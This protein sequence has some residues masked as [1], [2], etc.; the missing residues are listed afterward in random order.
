MSQNDDEMLRQEMD[1][2]QD[3]LNDNN[4]TLCDDCNAE[5][6]WDNTIWIQTRITTGEDCGA[7]T[8]EKWVCEVCA[9][10]CSKRLS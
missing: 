1:K 10:N 2:Y 7:I 8:G 3:Y 6:S 5:V 9:A 4:L